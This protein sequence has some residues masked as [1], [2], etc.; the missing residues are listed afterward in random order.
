MADNFGLKIGVEGEKQFKSALRDINQTFK[1]LGSEMKLVSSQF[2]KQDKSVQA[3]TARNEVLN[4]EIDAQKNKVSTLEAALKNAAESFGENDRR[5]Q[6]WQIQLNNA[7]A[8]LNKMERELDQNNKAL[9]EA[10]EGFDEAGNEADDFGDEIDSSAKVA[11]D[12]GGRFEKLGS[13]MKG[14]AAGIGVAMAAIGTAAVAAGKKLYDMAND[15]A[16]AG[17]EIDKSSQRIG[18]ST[19]GYQ[20]WDYVLS[21]NGASISTL[22]NGMKKLNNTV[23]DAIQGSGSAAERFKRLGIS[24]SDLEGKSREEIFEMTVRGLQGIADEGEKAAIANDLLGNSSV[25][26]AA[27][28]NQT[29]ES[30][31]DLKN[32]ASE[33]GLVMSDES[34]DAAVEYTDAMDNLTRSFTGVKNNITSQLLPGFTMILDGLTGLITGQEGAAEQLK[35]GA[36]ETVDQIAVILPQILDVVTGLIAAIAEVAPELVIALVNG[37][38]D[39]LPTLIDA[40]TNII[41]T[42]VGGLIEALPQITQGALQLVL[43]LVDGIIANLPALVEAALVMIVTLATGIGEALPELIPSIVEAVILIVETLINNLDLVLEAAFQI[44]SGLAQGILNALPTLIEA[45]PQIISSIITFITSNLPKIIEMGVQLTI[46]LAAGLIRAIPQL[47]AQIPQIITAIVT[48]LGKAIPAI[49]DV[50][51]NIARGLWD[52]IASM[53]TWLK[54]KVSDMVGGIV[55]GVKGLLGIRSPSQ[56]FAG[57]GENM[58]EGIGVGFEKAMDD[59]SEDMQ[60][61]IPTDFNLDSE[62]NVNGGA[63]GGY[64][65]LGG[66]LI[67]IQQMIVRSEDDIRK[68]SQELYNL[69]QTGSRA[70]GRF[71]TT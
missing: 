7:N 27:L 1:V 51:K 18:L 22:E 13:V 47:V 71:I 26:L 59:V 14:V 49:I 46:Q 42:I 36:K 69:M 35:A 11:D 60:K 64:G 62:V 38:L 67:T 19:E 45:L 5:T 20:E 44:I 57:I 58:G 37:I 2:D 66:S 56:V 29:A 65:M 30:T 63:G 54:N 15:A 53:V 52:G 17:D 16:A 40:A 23:D 61:V 48:G 4:K 70:Q 6:A 21:Q 31:E 28:L 41:M 33:L 32:K 8:D 43:T 50:G 10:S 9:N 39:N 24:M 25:E 3:L 12:A 68:I 34:I 55:K